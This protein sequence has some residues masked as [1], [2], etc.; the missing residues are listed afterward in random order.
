MT[1]RSEKQRNNKLRMKMED[2]TEM[3]THQAMENTWVR[4]QP[5]KVKVKKP[6]MMIHGTK[7][8]Q[9]MKVHQK[10]LKDKLLPQQ[11][12]QEKLLLQPPKIQKHQD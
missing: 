7:N 6:V 4:N 5:M 12:K 11:R 2:K 1:D 9:E 10:M 8:L 3:S